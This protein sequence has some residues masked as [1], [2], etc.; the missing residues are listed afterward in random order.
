MPPIKINKDITKYSN[1]I[2]TKILESA[3]I[4]NKGYTIYKEDIDDETI[5]KIKADLM[6]KPFAPPTAM[7]Q[8]T[9]F[10]IYRES[11]KKL[12]VP[13]YYGFKTFGVPYFDDDE[14]DSGA[15][16]DDNIK[17][18]NLSPDELKDIVAPEKI[19][20]M[21]QEG[22]DIDIEFKGG[23][24]EYQEKIVDTYI[25]KAVYDCGGG[26]L[27][28]PCGRGKCLAKG[29]MVMKYDGGNIPVEKIKNGDII[30]GDDFMP[31]YVWG[32]TSGI[33]DLYKIEQKLE[34]QPSNINDNNTKNEINSV[35][36]NEINSVIKNENNSLIKNEN[37]SVISNKIINVNTDK[38]SL[39]LLTPEFLSYT[40]NK[41]HILTLFNTSNGFIEDIYIK[42]LIDT[43]ELNGFHFVRE[44][45]RGIIAKKCEFSG[46]VKYYHT[47]LTNITY[48]GNDEYYGFCID[49]N[50]RFLLSS[51][52]VTHNTVMALNIISCVKKKTL[53]IVH[54][55]F[56]LNQW[57]ERIEQFLPTARVG[58]I[59]G[60]IIDIKDKDIVIGMLQS[61]SMKDYDASVFK[62]FGLTIIDE[63]HHISAEVFCRSLFKVVTPY[64]LGLSATMNRKDGLTKIFK[65]FIGD[66]VYSEKKQ[67]E[68]PVKVRVVNYKHDDPEFSETVYNYKGQTHYSIMIKKLCEFNNRS[69]FILLLLKEAIEYSKRINAE[70]TGEEK[71]QQIMILAH[72][73]N[74]L[75]YLY[76]AIEHRKMGTV[77]YYVGG[78]KESQLKETET[79]EIVIA[80][81]AMAEEALD[82]KTLSGLI[83]ATPKTDVTQAVGRILRMKHRNPFVIDIVDQHDIFQKQYNKRRAFYKKCNYDIY[84]TDSKTYI[85]KQKQILLKK[86]NINGEDKNIYNGIYLSYDNISLWKHQ[87]T[88]KAIGK[89]GNKN[90]CVDE[91]EDVYKKKDPVKMGKCLIKFKN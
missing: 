45:Y 59:Q 87:Y 35:I 54:K 55:E 22:D 34:S 64:M 43:I 14:V 31:R 82:I 53:V 1:A 61:L 60:K 23:L 9:P 65:M 81:Y 52:V 18:S 20:N 63:C 56:L 50:R 79:K 42:D 21:L 85:A 6:M 69:E 27:E 7:S 40:V 5:E 71:P 66:I 28:I 16:D 68:M 17:I 37:N 88:S 57:V 25:D 46:L 67:P 4:G 89:K 78:M 47:I 19:R 38:K 2:K 72:N 30:M 77:G 75:H 12:F 74:L 32:T 70:E 26:L 3:Y 15:D 73:K 91:D 48:A 76:D 83:L 41:E 39:E 33:S 58:R 10:P 36:K 62:S 8:P 44:K 86:G 84:R 49:G 24:R 80:T 13:R 11:T 51:G 90:K 29:T